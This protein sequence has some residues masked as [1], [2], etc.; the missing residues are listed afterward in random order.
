MTRGY[1]TFAGWDDQPVI[2]EGVTPKR[3]RVR[4][5]GDKLRMPLRGNGVRIV[6]RSGTVLVPKSAVRL[7]VVDLIDALRKALPR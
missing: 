3:Y 5:V 6:L 4:S 2:I 7:E 1:L